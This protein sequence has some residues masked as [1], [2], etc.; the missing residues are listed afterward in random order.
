MKP[1][2]VN[3]AS[4]HLGWHVVKE[5]QKRGYPVRASVTNIKDRE[6][7][8][9]LNDPGIEI[10]QSTLTDRNSLERAIRGCSAVFHVAAPFKMHA[11]DPKSAI[12]EPTL[13]GMQN[14]LETIRA[15]KIK[16]I[17]YTS[18]VGCVGSSGKGERPRTE[19]EWVENPDL[20]YVKAKTDAE[21]SFHDF[22]KRNGMQGVAALPSAMIGPNFIT[23]SPSVELFVRLVKGKVPAVLPAHFD[24]VDVRDVARGHVDLFEKE[25]A[26]GRY[27]LSGTGYWLHE[28]MQM[29]RKDFP[30]LK[31]P[32][33][34]LPEFLLPLAIFSDWLEDRIRKSGR[35]LTDDV[36]K[37][38]GQGKIQSFSYAK[39][40]KE[41]GWSPRPVEESV[42]DTI[43]W[44][45]KPD[46]AERE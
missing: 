41:I 8:R 35:L 43:E 36:I 34:I 3:G 42:R 40:K 17:I 19:D 15:E 44:I 45:K 31:I 46:F 12:Y 20:M 21:R 13:M 16:K 1:V 32:S 2:F 9:H 23:P 37:E 28:I 38:F 30:E 18:S 33:L 5:L 7:T 4:G 25:N 24:Y 26:S 39:A 6:K 22:I 10:V 11:K 29:I 27:I 14:I